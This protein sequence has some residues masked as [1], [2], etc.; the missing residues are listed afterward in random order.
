MSAVLSI[1]V[2]ADVAKAVSG[3]DKVES[4]TSQFNNGMRKAAPYA[5][6]AVAGIAGLGKVAF[7]AASAAEQAAGGMDAVFGA[8]AAGMQK[9]ADQAARNVGLSKTSYS[10]LATVLGAQL[11]NMGVS[12]D[13]LGKQTDDLVRLGADLAAQ[14]GGSTA[15]AVSALSSLMRGERDPIEKYGVAIKAADIEAQKAKMGLDGLTGE[16]AKTAETQ[17]MLAL[18]TDQTA[19]AQG[20]FA[21]EADTAAGAQQ[22]ATAAAQDAAADLGTALL[23]AVTAAALALQGMAE[24]ASE[25]TTVVQILAGVIA[26]IAAA[27]LIYNGVMKAVAIAQGIATVAQWAWNAALLANP[28][29]W[30]VIAIVALIAIIVLLVKNWDTVKAVAEKVWTA[31]V[32]AVKVAWNW[33]KGIGAKI[34]EFF[35]GVWNTVKAAATVAWNAIVT[36]VTNKVAAIQARVQAFRDRVA[37]IWTFIRTAA[38]AAWNAVSSA[39]VSVVTRIISKVQSIRDRVRSIFDSVRSTIRNAIDGAASS[40]SSAVNRIIGFFQRIIDRARSIASTV[41]NVFANIRLPSLPW[42]FA[43]ADPDTITTPQT[44]GSLA[45]A[46]TAPTINWPTRP[47]GSAGRSGPAV[48]ITVQGALDPAAVARQIRDL[49]NRDGRTRGVVDLG[50]VLIR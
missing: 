4:K 30:I 12:Q 35:K 41:A 27:I 23:P 20:A 34:G 18:L 9:L 16:A 46:S 36:W 31:V 39:V 19:S 17:A 7:D 49:L 13:D 38:Q 37:A 25:N 6:A 15:D 33:L 21:R 45:L 48:Q 24:W 1:E 2:V 47:G 40:V 43:A 10:E 42:P 28:I 11:K 50:G 32:A 22:R 29:T 44:A 5:A 26:G 3:L 14:F 8:E